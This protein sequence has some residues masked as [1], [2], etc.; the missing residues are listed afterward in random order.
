MTGKLILCATP[1][2]NLGDITPRVLEALRSADLI[3]AEDTRNSKK[4][5][6]HFDIHTPMISYHENNRFD[7]GREL[8]AKMEEGAVVAL[9]TD[10]GTPAI[11][12]PGEELVR[13]AYEAGIE[14]TSLPGAAACITALTLSGLSTA[15]FAME[16]FLPRAKKEREALLNEL[17]EHTETLLFYEAPHRLQK[18]LQDLCDAF[19]PA[20]RIAICR[21]LTKIHEEVLH[22][23]LGEAASAVLQ[24]P[25]NAE[26]SGAMQNMRST[27][28]KAAGSVSKMDLTS[29]QAPRGEFVLVVEGKSQEQILQEKQAQWESLT[30]AEHMEQYLAE[31]CDE[32]EAMKRVAKDRGC[33]KRDIYALWKKG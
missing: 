29:L 21:E 10:A 2:G 4:L 26:K 32:K 19:G 6:T 33:S 7:R 20:R 27:E 30:L 16:G 1:I 14:V 31:G 3:A 28:Q 13:M 24:E 17:K 15:R 11:S 23:T 18:T 25:R 9:I 22:L 12:D 5:L 8:I